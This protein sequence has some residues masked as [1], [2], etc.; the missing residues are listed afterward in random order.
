M[1]R[2]PIT[3][4]MG[5][6]ATLASDGAKLKSRKKNMLNSCLVSSSG[7]S[8]LQS[9]DATGLVKDGPYLKV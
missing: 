7:I 6:G 8:F 4:V 5:T 9:T 2:E 1:I 3:A